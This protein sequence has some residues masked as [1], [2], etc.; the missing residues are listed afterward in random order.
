MKADKISNQQIKA[1]RRFLMM[2]PHGKD[3]DLVLLKAHLLIEEQIRQIVDERLINPTVLVRAN[4]DC[5]QAI[6]I[7]QAFFPL[8]HQPWLWNSLK[9]LNGIRNGIAHNLESPGL[10]DKIEDFISSF[11]SMF[12][13]TE[14][15]TDRFE[16]TL[17]SLFVAVSQLVTTPSAQVLKLVHENA[18]ITQ[19]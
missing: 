11:P 12:A 1:F 19:R 13:S 8:D 5:N 9:K 3:R 16:L 7:A 4:I 2:M 14:N 6:C 10:N 17:W 15:E 18:S